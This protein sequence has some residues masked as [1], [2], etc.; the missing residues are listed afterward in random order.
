MERALQKISAT[1]TNINSPDFA[2]IVIR[3]M[4]GETTSPKDLVT[5][6]CFH[7]SKRISKGRVGVT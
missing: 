4:T 5:R 7:K 1:F 6:R 3:S 2:L